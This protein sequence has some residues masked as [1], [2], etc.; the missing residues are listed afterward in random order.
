[1]F[2]YDQPTYFYA[3][4]LLLPVALLFVWNRFWARKTIKRFGDIDLVQR[5]MPENNTFKVW[6]KFVSFVLAFIA[7][8]LALVN[9]KI[10]S[11]T[12]TVKREG[13]DIVFAVDVSRSMLAEDVS[14]NRLE[15]TKQI[16]SQ[17]INQL[18]GDRVGIVAYAGN[19]FPVLP[20]TTDYAAAKMFLQ[21][22]NTEMISAQGTSFDQAIELAST[23][24]DQDASVSRLMILISDGEDHSEGLDAS[25]EILKEK[26]IKTIT[27]GIGTEKGG[28][29]PIK[30]NGVVERFIRDSND[31]VV[32]T[33]LDQSTLQSIASASKGGYILGNQ[34][35][36]VINY[37]EQALENIEKTEFETTQISDFNSQFQWFI[38]FALFWLILDVL[39]LERRTAWVY[40]LN[41]FNEK[42]QE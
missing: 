9:P 23:Y 29:M 22:M 24:F 25:L 20:I 3:L 14:P 8:A 35:K 39:F 30:R 42:K 33:R 21:S 38:A 36:D 26:N 40:K 5:L 34:T 1:M 4:L 28:P 17:I 10:G 7:L 6:L 37:L 31:E 19:A 12:E 32:I 16:V 41:L 13:I 2:V 27:I 15:K 11:K 18:A